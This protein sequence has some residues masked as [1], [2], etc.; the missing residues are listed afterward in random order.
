[1]VRGHAVAPINER[2]VILDNYII[3]YLISVCSDL[4]LQLKYTKRSMKLAEKFGLASDK[5]KDK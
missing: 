5:M 3:K 4:C 2:T 1:M